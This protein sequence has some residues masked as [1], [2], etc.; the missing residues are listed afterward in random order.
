MCIRDSIPDLEHLGALQDLHKPQPSGA[1]AGQPNGGGGGAAPGSDPAAMAQLLAALMGAAA[2]QQQG[3][4]GQ[5][6]P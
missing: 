3:Q 2:Q 4:N 1:R 6:N 5:G